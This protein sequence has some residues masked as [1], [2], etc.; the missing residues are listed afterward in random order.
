MRKRL[1]AAITLV[2]IAASIVPTARLRRP[3]RRSASSTALSK[4]ARASSS[5]RKK[6]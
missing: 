6:L 4:V 3:T 1:A 2:A 5:A